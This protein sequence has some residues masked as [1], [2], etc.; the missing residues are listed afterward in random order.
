MR[1][2]PPTADDVESPLAGQPNDVGLTAVNEGFGTSVRALRDES[3]DDPLAGRRTWETP[4][5]IEY[6]RHDVIHGGGI[7][8]MAAAKRGSCGTFDERQGSGEQRFEIAH[9]AYRLPGLQ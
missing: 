9:V 5:V 8:K 3:S 2:A 4:Q 6:P 7:G 1:D